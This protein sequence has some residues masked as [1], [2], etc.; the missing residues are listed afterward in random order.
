MQRNERQQ[1][2]QTIS[3]P[4]ERMWFVL[5]VCPKKSSHHKCLYF[6]SP[7]YL[8]IIYYQDFKNKKR[9]NHIIQCKTY[10]CDSFFGCYLW[11]LNNEMTSKGNCISPWW[12]W[13]HS[14]G[15]KC[16]SL[17]PSRGI[18]TH[19]DGRDVSKSQWEFITLMSHWVEKY[20]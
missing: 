14:V 1:L 3:P 8:S 5:Y 4:H 7:I 13:S 19:K 18:K 20:F 17:A 15:V 6:M 16:K 11:I 9:K 12:F 10:F 2:L